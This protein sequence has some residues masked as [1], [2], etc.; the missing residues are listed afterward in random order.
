MPERIR[1]SLRLDPQRAL[2]PAPRMV[3]RIKER[4]DLGDGHS[5]LGFAGFHDFVSGAHRPFL[6]DAEVEARP[7]AGSQQ[8]GHPR[9][10][11]PNADPITGNTR[12]SDLEQRAA[13]LIAVADAYAIIG[14][15]FD[16]EVLA[17]LSVDKVGPL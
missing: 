10:V 6:E 1:I 4:V 16:R 9:V 15:S 13:D 7:A 12:L 8:C 5:L 3:R 2:Q 17:E 11:H 14:Q